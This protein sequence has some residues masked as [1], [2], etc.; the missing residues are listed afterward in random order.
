MFP[1]TVLLGHSSLYQHFC[2]RSVNNIQL[3][4]ISKYRSIKEGFKHFT[5]STICWKAQVTNI[6]AFAVGS[7]TVV[8]GNTG[9]WRKNS[10][11][12]HLPRLLVVSLFN[13]V[14]LRTQILQGTKCSRYV[15]E[16]EG[17]IG[18]QHLE[19]LA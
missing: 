5:C 10:V 3:F 1:G 18:A 13:H 19:G 17:I 2:Y 6:L 9:V 7:A 15:L 11:H 14:R 16:P 8:Q 4:C 12:L